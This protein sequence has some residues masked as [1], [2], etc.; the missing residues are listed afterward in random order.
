[1]APERENLLSRLG[2]PDLQTVLSTRLP[3]TNAVC[4]PVD[5]RPRCSYHVDVASE[6]HLVAVV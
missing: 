5:S 6:G 1:M 3:L 4:R 2:I